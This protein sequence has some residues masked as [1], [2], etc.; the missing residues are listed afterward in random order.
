MDWKDHTDICTLMLFYVMFALLLTVS[1]LSLYSDL[2]CHKRQ[3][4]LL[5]R[6]RMFENYKI[7]PLNVLVS[8]VTKA[9]NLNHIICVVL[10][11]CDQ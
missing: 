7:E 6:V 5:C 1:I 9:Y 2:E 10:P 8:L 3:K 11:G 4:E